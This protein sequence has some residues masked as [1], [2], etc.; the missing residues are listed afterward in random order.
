M[1]ELSSKFF[2]LILYVAQDDTIGV[3]FN[4]Y[5]EFKRRQEDRDNYILFSSAVIKID[6]ELKELDYDDSIC[7]PDF[8][9]KEWRKVWFK[10]RPDLHKGPTVS[11]EYAAKMRPSDR[12]SGWGRRDNIGGQAMNPFTKEP[13][14]IIAFVTQNESS[15]QTISVAPIVAF[16]SVNPIIQKIVG[17]VNSDIPITYDFTKEDQISEA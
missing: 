16:A 14:N 1:K 9:D 3:V 8:S 15:L 2:G 13:Y 17:P 12:F 10:L 6:D 4:T 5:L 7:L 11:E